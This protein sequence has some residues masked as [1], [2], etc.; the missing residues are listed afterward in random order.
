MFIIEV[1]LVVAIAYTVY[2]YLPKQMKDSIDG[3]VEIGKR[4]IREVTKK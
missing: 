1:V 3:Y 4:K 2:L